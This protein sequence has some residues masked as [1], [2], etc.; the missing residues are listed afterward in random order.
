MMDYNPTFIGE[1]DAGRRSR[2][3]NVRISLGILFH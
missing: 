1:T 3:D 2:L